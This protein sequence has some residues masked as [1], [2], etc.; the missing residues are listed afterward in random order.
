MKI[1]PPLPQVP[2]V[3]HQPHKHYTLPEGSTRPVSSPHF[4]RSLVPNHLAHLAYQ[5]PAQPYYY[6]EQSIYGSDFDDEGPTAVVVPNPVQPVA[7]FQRG[8]GSRRSSHRS[9]FHRLPTHQRLV[10]DSHPNQ[11]SSTLFFTSPDIKA[12]TL[13]VH[14]HCA[15]LIPPPTARPLPGKSPQA[16]DHLLYGPY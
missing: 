9:S 4:P 10:T 3:V 2:P 8:T 13:A 1:P 7:Y 11:A 15:L 12:W 16:Q 5:P 6:G 14:F